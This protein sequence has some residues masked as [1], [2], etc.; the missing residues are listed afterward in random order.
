MS[1]QTKQYRLSDIDNFANIILN[2]NK[3]PNF[4]NKNLHYLYRYMYNNKINGNHIYSLIKTKEKNININNIKQIHQIYQTQQFG[5][6]TFTTDLSSF[7]PNL[8]YKYT[9]KYY[10]STGNNKKEII[11]ESV[12][13]EQSTNYTDCISVAYENKDKLDIVTLK[14]AKTCYTITDTN[15]NIVTNQR[16][17]SGTIM[18][19]IILSYAKKHKFKSITLLDKAEYICET[20]KEKIKY[21][22]SYVGTLCDGQ[23]WYY[24]FGFKYQNIY[25]HNKVINNKNKLLEIKTS[26]YSFEEIMTLFMKTC[27]ELN[28]YN[29]FTDKEFIHDLNRFP[30]V[31]VETKDKCIM[32]FFKLMREKCCSI[33]AVMELSFFYLL[34]LEIYGVKT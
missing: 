23:P 29:Y 34:N 4:K 22:M 28:K 24:K 30:Q 12:Q 9:I 25:E 27:I 2:H 6:S 8:N 3:D 11:V 20:E 21:N 26:N 15:N 18:M 16:N 1:Q 5:G 32:E 31:Y 10:K 7:D 19:Y 17:N 13:T 33:L 14:S